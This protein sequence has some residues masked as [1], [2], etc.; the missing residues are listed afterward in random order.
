MTIETLI[1]LRYCLRLGVPLGVA[2]GLVELWLR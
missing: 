2:L 1:A